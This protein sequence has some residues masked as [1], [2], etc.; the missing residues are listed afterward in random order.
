MSD[1]LLIEARGVRKHFPVRTTSFGPAPL[2]RAVDGVDLAI[3]KGE[4]LGL[5]GEMRLRQVDAGPAV[6]AADRTDSGRDPA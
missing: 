5:V 2:V 4:T 6:P 3:R 1:T